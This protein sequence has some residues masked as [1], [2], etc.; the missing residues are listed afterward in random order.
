[1]ALSP[2]P[3]GRSMAAVSTLGIIAF[4]FLWA[5]SL[6]CGNTSLMVE[7]IKMVGG[8]FGGLLGGYGIGRMTKRKVK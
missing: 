3:G 6:S 1:M 8:V 4:C 5:F 7:L 2:L